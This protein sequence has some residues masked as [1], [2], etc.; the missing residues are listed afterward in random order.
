MSLKLQKCLQK[1]NSFS[2]HTL[3]LEE[4]AIAIFILYVPEI[5]MHGFVG[6]S[7]PLLIFFTHRVIP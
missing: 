6:G 4:V 2:T 1:I 5:F 7:M 3:S